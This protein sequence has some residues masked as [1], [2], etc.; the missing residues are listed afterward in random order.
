MRKSNLLNNRHLVAVDVNNTFKICGNP[1]IEELIAQLVAVKNFVERESHN[2]FNSSTFQRFLTLTL[3]RNNFVNS[4]RPRHLRIHI[5]FTAVKFCD[6]DRPIFEHPIKIRAMR[7]VSERVNELDL[8][9][10]FAEAQLCGYDSM[11]IRFA[12]IFTRWIHVR[13]QREHC[14][15]IHAVLNAFLQQLLLS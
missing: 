8:L 14:R 4:A 15:T 5:F 3:V 7:V 10:W 13:Q 6:N 12:S 9:L 11:R 1:G 2:A